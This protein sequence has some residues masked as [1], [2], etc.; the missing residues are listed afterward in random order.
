[1]CSYPTIHNS[2]QMPRKL[3]CNNVILNSIYYYNDCIIYHRRVSIIV[4]QRIDAEIHCFVLLCITLL[5]KRDSIFAA[6]QSGTKEHA[7]KRKK[8]P[9][10]GAKIWSH[11]WGVSPYLRLIYGPNTGQ[12][13]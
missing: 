12:N 7:D 5:K 6:L 9:A 3:V 13:M 2:L 10:F 11:E 8:R 1:M 4:I